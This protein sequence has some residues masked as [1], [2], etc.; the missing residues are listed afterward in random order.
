MLRTF[1]RFA[2]FIRDYRYYRRRGL[3]SKAAWHLASMTLP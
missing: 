3:N 2:P 1:A